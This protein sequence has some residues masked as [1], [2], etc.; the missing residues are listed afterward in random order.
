MP[1]TRLWRPHAKTLTTDEPC[2]GGICGCAAENEALF[3]VKQ[4]NYIKVQSCGELPEIAGWNEQDRTWVQPL[5]RL[6]TRT[7]VGRPVLCKRRPDRYLLILY[8]RRQ[9]PAGIRS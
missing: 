2:A 7:V 6:I 3:E 5:S 8:G 1:P 4:L 9:S